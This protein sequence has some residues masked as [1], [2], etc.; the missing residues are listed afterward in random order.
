MSDY[1]THYY[2]ELFALPEIDDLDLTDVETENDKSKK[3]NFELP[4]FEPTMKCA[5]VDKKFVPAIVDF[6]DRGIMCDPLAKLSRAFDNVSS[7]SASLERIEL[8]FQFLVGLR[9]LLQHGLQLLDLVRCLSML[10]LRVYIFSSVFIKLIHNLSVL[11]FN[12][13][14]LF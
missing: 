8:R 5:R 9:L 12:F 3:L 14:F 1:V 6:I 10:L 11:I 13:F 4:I 7:S 2:P